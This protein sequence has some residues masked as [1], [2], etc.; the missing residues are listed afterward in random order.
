[1]YITTTCVQRWYFMLPLSGR[2]RD[3]FLSGR[4]TET[5]SPIRL[6]NGGSESRRTD[7]VSGS[8]DFDSDFVRRFEM[9]SSGER[10]R[11]F[12]SAIRTTRQDE[13]ERAGLRVFGSGLQKNINIMLTA[14]SE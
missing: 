10:R 13:L 4:P 9:Q 5:T 1:M 11:R 12:E 2:Y 8:K 6:S 7:S 3:K 14:T